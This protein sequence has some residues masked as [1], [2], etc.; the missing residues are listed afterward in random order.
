[1]VYDT[2]DPTRIA[3]MNDEMRVI[4]SMVIVGVL[5]YT[6]AGKEHGSWR[7]SP[8]GFGVTLRCKSARDHGACGKKAVGPVRLNSTSRTTLLDC[9]IELRRKLQEEHGSTCIKAQHLRAQFCTQQWV[10]EHADK[11]INQVIVMYLDVDQIERPASPADVSPVKGILSSYSFLFLGTPGHYAMRAYSCWCPACSRVRGRGHG[12]NS[13]GASLEVPGCERKKLTSWK[14]DKFTVR[15]M[16]G[17]KEREKRM[18]EILNKEIPRAK[19]G[20]WA[21]VQAR[22]LWSTEEEVHFRPGHHW[23]CELGDAGDGTSCEKKFELGPRRW[24]DYKGTRF[25]NGDQALVI[26]RWL[27]RVDEDASGLTFEEW[28]PASEADTSQEPVA[29]IINSSELR[30]AGFK[31]KEVLPPQLESAARGGMRT[32]GAGLRRLQGMGPQRFL[33]HVDDDTEF[34]SRCE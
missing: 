17:I 5:K 15:P 31:L 7:D 18:K 24:E 8:A 4:E 10:S 25:Y 21:C 29:M 27:N 33:L 34:R 32:R 20:N 12:A 16:S 28:D 13:L 2:E 19:P 9:L 6:P 22:E 26:K 1:M 14:E 30:A 23:L 3:Q 11:K